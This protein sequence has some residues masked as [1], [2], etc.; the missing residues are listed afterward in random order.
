MDD[1]IWSSNFFPCGK[2]KRSDGGGGTDGMCE[3]IYRAS[4]DRLRTPQFTG[5]TVIEKDKG[6]TLN[7]KNRAC[8][9]GESAYG[10]SN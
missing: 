5:I 7:D 8:N 2:D 3:R 1:K 4:E 10:S 6:L 9:G